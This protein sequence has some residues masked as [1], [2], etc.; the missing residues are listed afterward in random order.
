[1][2]IR[3]FTVAEHKRVSTILLERYGKLV[4]TQLADSELQLGMDPA[5]LSHRVRSSISSG[6][7]T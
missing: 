7:R 3:D 6:K 2:N 1:M 5:D 4:P